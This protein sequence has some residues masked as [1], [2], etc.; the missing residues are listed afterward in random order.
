MAL[1][2]APVNKGASFSVEEQKYHKLRGL[3]PSEV[4]S[5]EIQMERTLK[6]MRRKQDDIEI[7][8]F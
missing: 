2:S 3:L 6:N 4:V 8:I 7:Y 5:S 1:N